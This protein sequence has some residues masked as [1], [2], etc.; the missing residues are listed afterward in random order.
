[1]SNSLSLCLSSLAMRRLLPQDVDP[2]TSILKGLVNPM[3]RSPPVTATFDTV[4]AMPQAD[5]DVDVD[6]R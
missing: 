4:A 3:D 5:A 6:L 1:M 2:L